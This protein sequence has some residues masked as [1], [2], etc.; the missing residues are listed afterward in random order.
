MNPYLMAALQP[1]IDEAR[2]QSQI[3]QMMND[4]RLT[5]AGAYG[6][7]RQAIMNA[8]T[9]RNLG[10]NLAGITGTGYKDAYD[11]AMQQFNTEQGRGMEAQ[12][13]L[14]DYGMGALAAQQG[15]GAVQRQIEGEGI[16]A[17]KKAFEEERDDPYKK[18][19]YGMSLLQGMPVQTQSYSYQQPSTLSNIAST[20]GG[21][22][23]LY[24]QIFG[25]RPAT[26]PPA[27]TPGATTPPG[28]SP[29]S[30]TPR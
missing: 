7:S 20:A 8:E 21:T 18:I 28:T 4:A 24:D 25:T 1:Q 29:G 14:N 11:K 5:K 26:T 3:T 13:M 6:G 9:Q 15:A 30:T 19:Q 2:R 22:M 23:S 16:A 17:D 12:K 10:T 27:T